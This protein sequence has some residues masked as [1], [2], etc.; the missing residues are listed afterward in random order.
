MCLDLYEMIF[1]KQCQ[2]IIEIDFFDALLYI[3]GMKIGIISTYLPQRCGIATYTD[4]LT[5]AMLKNT[6]LHIKIIAEDLAQSRRE[7]RLEV[8]PAWNRNE[9]YP[10][11]I[12]PLVDDVDVLHIQH[13]YSIYSF[14][15]RLPSLL[16]SIEKKKIITIHCIRPAQ[17]CERGDVDEKYAGKVAS[18]ADKV[19]VHLETQKAILERLG[20]PEDK[21]HVIPHGTRIIKEDPVES[22]RRFNLPENGKIMLI[23]GFI[24]PHKCI[25][26]AMDALKIILPKVD[27]YLFIG[28]WIAPN[29]KPEHRE[30]VDFLIDKMKKDSLEDRVIFYKGFIPEEDVTYAFSASDVVLFPYYEEDRSASGSF[31]LAIGAGR[32]VIASRIPKFEELKNISDELLVLPY[33]AEGLAGILLRLFTEKDFERYIK[34]RVEVYKEKTSWE[35]TAKRHL[36]VYNEDI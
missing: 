11:K 24:K 27:A 28:G 5:D 18:L 23:F 34:E 12:I 9:D 36:E 21:I 19:I 8:I 7:E 3:L 17:F 35:T 20:I 14:D 31:H 29:A 26:I 25:H 30:Y 32:P 2:R 6:D 13:E 10:K 33:N 4:Y 15:S 22:R 1:S 16:E